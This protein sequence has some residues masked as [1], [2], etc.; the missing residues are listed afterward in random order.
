MKRAV[1]LDRD[2]VLNPMVES[3]RSLGAPLTAD[4]FAIYPGTASR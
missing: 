2:G 4:A 1:F 3:E